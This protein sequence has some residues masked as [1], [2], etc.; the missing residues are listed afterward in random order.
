MSTSRCKGMNI[1]RKRLTAF[2]P[3]HRPIF[4]H[5]LP[6]QFDAG[7]AHSGIDA[8]HQAHELIG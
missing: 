7:L 4:A 2:P 6:S 8:I 5:A 3:L 1:S